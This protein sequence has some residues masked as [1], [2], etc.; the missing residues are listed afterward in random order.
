VEPPQS[1][2][3]IVVAEDDPSSRE[4]VCEILEAQ[5]YHVVE[6][7]N[8]PDALDKI[9]KLIPDL[10]LMDIQMPGAG[11]MTVIQQIRQDRRTAKVPVVAVTAHAMAG[12]RERILSSGFDGYISKP[13]DAVLLR[14]QVRDLL[15][16][17]TPV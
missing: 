16:A 12:D 4:L 5:G 6:T 9:Q 2:K 13:V 3:T 8:G 7:G 14:Q 1:L 11:G 15:R 17:G 10:V